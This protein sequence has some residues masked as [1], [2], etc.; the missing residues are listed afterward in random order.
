MKYWILLVLIVAGCRNEVG[1]PT[2]DQQ[3][4]EKIEETRF[5]PNDSEQ[6]NEGETSETEVQEGE[7]NDSSADES[8][9]STE[10]SAFGELE[11]EM[12]KIS[13]ELVEEILNLQKVLC[14]FHQ[15]IESTD[16]SMCEVVVGINGKWFSLYKVGEEYIL[17]P[18][19]FKVEGDQ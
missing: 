14:E 16:K 4:Q 1:E 5:G 10:K 9:E 17:G 7:P 19:P 18:P 2:L 12:F 3:G 8:K 15:D 13:E 6:P 11:D